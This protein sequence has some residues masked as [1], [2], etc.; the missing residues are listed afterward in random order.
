MIKREVYNRC[1]RIIISIALVFGCFGIS[2]CSS[3]STSSTSSSS[4]SSSTMSASLAQAKTTSSTKNNSSKS[5]SSQKKKSSSKKK[6]S[7]SKKSSSKK[8]ASKNKKSSKKTS[9]A[10]KKSSKKSS[11]A[12]KK[13]YRWPT[14]NPT[15]LKIPKSERYY[16]ARKYVGSRH[17]IAGPVVNVYQATSSNGQPTFI[18]IGAKYPSSEC[19]TFLIWADDMNSDFREMLSDIRS[20]GNAWLKVTGYVSM[21]NGRPQITTGSGSVSYTWWTNAN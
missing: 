18:D 3:N 15:L 20:G 19:F 11:S 13:D 10:K 9:S 5:Q 7:K 8:K 2:A 4:Q 1:L 12:S 6:A 21:Y 17:T 14:S 16:N